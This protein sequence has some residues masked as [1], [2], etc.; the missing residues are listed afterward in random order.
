MDDN[1]K[2]LLETLS[3][4]VWNTRE[5]SIGTFRQCSFCCVSPENQHKKDCPV[6]SAKKIL[7]KMLE[8]E[9]K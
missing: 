7:K 2:K 8:S 5:T 1:L 9:R 3:E 6:R 4:G